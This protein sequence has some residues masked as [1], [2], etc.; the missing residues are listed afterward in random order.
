MTI[1]EMSEACIRANCLTLE[2]VKK[3]YEK[4]SRVLAELS[5]EI[6]LEHFNRGENSVIFENGK[7][8][9]HNTNHT[10]YDADE[11][12]TLAEIS[13][14]A[15]DFIESIPGMKY[16][17]SVKIDLFSYELQ[18]I[19]NQIALDDVTDFFKKIYIEEIRKWDTTA[20]EEEE[21]FFIS[22]EEL[23]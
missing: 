10:K 4:V 16:V 1:K 6:V 23:E 15:D 5:D 19:L 3:I 13:I 2:S 22:I 12:P 14:D 20:P 21:F 17:E 8:F 18:I 11:V 7:L 9:F